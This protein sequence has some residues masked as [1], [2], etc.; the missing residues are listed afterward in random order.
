[1]KSQAFQ[2]FLQAVLADPVL[3]GQCGAVCYRA[4]LVPLA[5]QAGL[6]IPPES[7]SSGRT[8]KPFPAPW[9]PWA[10]GG[11]SQRTAVLSWPAAMR[12]VCGRISGG[13]PIM[14]FIR[15]GCGGAGC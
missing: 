13:L 2:Q 11:S 10:R 14:G 15:D 6:A 9:W 8:T 7:C 3:Q 4:Q 12:P 1:M 5:Q